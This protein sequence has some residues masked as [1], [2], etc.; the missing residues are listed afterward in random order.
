MGRRIAQGGGETVNRQIV[1][2]SPTLLLASLTLPSARQLADAARRDRSRVVVLDESQPKVVHGPRT[3]YGGTD[4]AAQ[5]VSEYNLLLIEPPLDLLARL[6]ADLVARTV[7]F[8]SLRQLGQLGGPIFV[9]PADPLLKVFDAGV[10][11]SV[12]QVRGR[13]PIDPATLVLASEPVEWTT[14]Y[15]CF[16]REGVVEAWSPYLSF[17]R[18]SWKPDCAG[19]IPPSLTAF[20]DRF[21]SR[22]RDLPPAFVMDV[23]VLEDG[24][25]AVVEF[26]PAWCSS[27]LGASVDGVYRVLRR[28]ATGAEHALD[29]DRRWTIDLRITSPSSSSR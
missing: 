24:R 22:V 3:F 20:C 9:K 1:A 25:W 28:A 4:R 29:D 13:R 17:G 2:P 21:V 8:G 12:D 19:V 26:N 27:I 6:P 14:E 18:P 11:R 16:I 23:G 10:H 7:R 15:R 5:Y